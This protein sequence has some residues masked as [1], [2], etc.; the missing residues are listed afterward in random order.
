MPHTHYLLQWN[1]FWIPRDPTAC[2]FLF[3]D[4]YPNTDG[5]NVFGKALPE[6]M[7]GATVVTGPP[8]AQWFRYAVYVG[9]DCRTPVNNAFIGPPYN[10]PFVPQTQWVPVDSA[11]ATNC[12]LFSHG[13]GD[14]GIAYTLFNAKI[15]FRNANTVNVTLYAID[16]TDP[17][18]CR[19]NMIMLNK[20]D[21]R[22][23]NGATCQV[24]TIGTALTGS[25]RVWAVR[26]QNNRDPTS[27]ASAVGA[28]VS[29]V[30]AASLAMLVLA[31]MRE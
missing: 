23:D 3:N 8:A 30:L 24:I 14:N 15:A 1:P 28:N 22:I 6:T 18:A 2:T 7:T 12:S 17:L 20:P 29:S 13:T 19:D 11:T 27:G 25:M 31:K 21:L 5:T 26:D 10:P 4:K 9:T 16:Q